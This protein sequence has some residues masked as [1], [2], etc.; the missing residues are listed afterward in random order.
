M[1]LGDFVRDFAVH[2]GDT[3]VGVV[4]N[5]QILV[6]AVV[7]CTDIRINRAVKDRQAEGHKASFFGAAPRSGAESVDSVTAQAFDE[8]APSCVFSPFDL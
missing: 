6:E 3:D 2:S 8:A 5:G 1:F 4:R 7:V